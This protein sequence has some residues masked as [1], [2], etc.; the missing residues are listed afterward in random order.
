MAVLPLLR[1]LHMGLESRI[2]AAVE[3][4]HGLGIGPLP[5]HLQDVRMELTVLAVVPA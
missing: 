2:E 3:R 5:E 4:V 1:I